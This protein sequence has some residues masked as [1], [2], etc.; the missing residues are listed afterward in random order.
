MIE[1]KAIE[2]MIEN[3]YAKGEEIEA[4]VR[5]RVDEELAEIL[6]KISADIDKAREDL[7]GYDPNSLGVFVSRVDEI[8]ENYKEVSR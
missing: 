4:E 2:A 6:D 1:A 5:E 7:D 3:E 8:I